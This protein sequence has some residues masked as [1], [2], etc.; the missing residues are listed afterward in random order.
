MHLSR[1]QAPATA[2]ICA[3]AQEAA[4]LIDGLAARRLG[5]APCEAYASPG[6]ARAR[7]TLIVICGMGLGAAA[8]TTTVTLRRW[9]PGLVVNCG[10]AGALRDDFGIGDVICI[11]EAIRFGDE[12]NA[13]IHQLSDSASERTLSSARR[14]RL[15]SSATPVFEPTLRATLAAYA[16]L[17]DMEGAAIAEVCAAHRVPCALLKAVSDHADDRASLQ[18]N[19][20]AASHVL[21]RHVLTHYR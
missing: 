21:A 18:R 5:D 3:T 15:F 2:F 7:A 8:A 20:A 11:D 1:D 19:L 17:V 14:G 4:P 16:D 6:N 12:G 10:I 9:S 13:V